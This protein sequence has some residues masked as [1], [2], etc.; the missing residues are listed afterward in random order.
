MKARP[1]LAIKDLILTDRRNFY[2]RMHVNLAGFTGT[3]VNRLR[4]RK[5]VNRAQSFTF[6]QAFHTLSLTLLQF[7]PVQCHYATAEIHL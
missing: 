7:A 2:M 5:K 3:T 4:K 1:L 6:A